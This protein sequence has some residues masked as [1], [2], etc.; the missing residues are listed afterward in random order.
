MGICDIPP[1]IYR[2]FQNIKPRC[3]SHPACSWIFG[4]RKKQGQIFPNLQT[5]S[6]FSFFTKQEFTGQLKDADERADSTLRPS[7]NAKNWAATA[8]RRFQKCPT[9]Q[10]RLVKFERGLLSDSHVI[11]LQ[12]NHKGCDVASVFTPVLSFRATFPI[13]CRDCVVPR[14]QLQ[15]FFT[16]RIR[17]LSVSYFFSLFLFVS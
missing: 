9:C 14:R 17:L 13:E 11:L 15:C 10:R 2:S 4:P 5:R 8:R 3:R 12:T 6:N 7:E 1:L 16:I